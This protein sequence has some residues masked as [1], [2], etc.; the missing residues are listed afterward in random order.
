MGRGFHFEIHFE[1]GG[2]FKIFKGGIINKLIN[3]YYEESI[4]DHESIIG[5]EK[6]SI[7]RV[8]EE[9]WLEDRSDSLGKNEVRIILLQECVSEL[10]R[11][12]TAREHVR[13]V[14]ERIGFLWDGI[15][16]VVV[17]AEG[18]ERTDLHPTSAQLRIRVHC[19]T[20][21]IDTCHWHCVQVEVE[22][23]RKRCLQVDPSRSVVTSP[24]LDELASTRDLRT[25][26]N[27]RKLVA[28][29]F[30]SVVR[31]DTLGV[32]VQVMEIEFTEISTWVVRGLSVFLVVL[33]SILTHRLLLKRSILTTD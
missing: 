8:V 22:D 31:S 16:R 27:E 33:R 5:V 9:D 3:Y 32:P 17:S 28:H 30:Q 19:E 29:F 12:T 1:L 18:I 13:V 11:C 4:G 14:G 24:V 20:A 15:I 7:C 25:R 23:F 2:N 6:R 21:N 10:Q 26:N